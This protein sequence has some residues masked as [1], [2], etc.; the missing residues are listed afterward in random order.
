[1]AYTPQQNRL[2]ERT[3]K[4]LF[5]RI[6]SIL[7]GLDLSKYF[8]AKTLKIACCLINKS[9][10]LAISFITPMERWTRH[11]PNFKN[12]KAFEYATYAHTKQDKLEARSLK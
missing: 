7:D 11:S 3:N 6:K 8:W 9:P 12:L 4:T 5:K 1:M 10:L 2:V